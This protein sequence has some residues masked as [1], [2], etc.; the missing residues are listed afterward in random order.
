MQDVHQEDGPPLKKQRFDGEA[1]APLAGTAEISDQPAAPVDASTSQEATDVSAPASK[2]CDPDNPQSLAWHLK[3]FTGVASEN[4]AAEALAGIS[5]YVNPSVPA[6]ASA[7]I[8]HRF[9]DFLVWEI[10]RGGEVVRLKNIARPETPAMQPQ[11]EQGK[12][13][14][15]PAAAEVEAAQPEEPTLES[16]VDAVKLEEIEGLAAGGKSDSNVLTNPIESKDARKAFHNALRKKYEGKLVSEA[17]DGGVINVTWGSGK[18]RERRSIRP[19]KQDQQGLPPFI[20][21]T[22]Q[23][24]NR[25]TQDCISHLASRIGVTPK[26]FGTAGTKDKRGVTTQLV[27]VRRYK[28]TIE[29]LWDQVNGLHHGRSR[30]AFR[31]GS[32]K[33][34]GNLGRDGMMPK[35]RGERGLRIGDLSYTKDALDLGMLEGNKFG[36]VLRDVQAQSEEVINA[37]LQTL[38]DTGFINFYGMQRFGNSSVPTHAVGLALLQSDW[39]G[40]AR[41]VMAERDGD[42]DELRYARRCWNDKHDARKALQNMPKWAVAERCLL[43]FYQKEGDTNHNGALSRIPKNLRMMY[44]HAYQSYVWNSVASERVKVHGCEKPVVGDLVLAEEDKSEDKTEEASGKLRINGKITQQSLQAA[45]KVPKVKVL[46]EADIPNYTMHDVVLPL[47][48]YSVSYPG[49]DLGKMYREMM[50]ADGLDADSMF[51]PQREF[52]LGG[53]Y[54]KILTKPNNTTWEVLHYSDS[55]YP[56]MQA[57]EDT[58]LGMT[59]PPPEENA[60]KTAIKVSFDLDTS[61]Y[62]TMALREIL[63]SETSNVHQKALTDAMMARDADKDAAKE[64]SAATATE[65][66]KAAGEV[67]TVKATEI[68]P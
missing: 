51:R 43:E 22:L 48:G 20:Q 54:R 66:E 38:H 50:K 60:D 45:S 40:A 4:N 63:K 12:Q 57:D 17:Q 44:V 32:Y 1:S 10:A 58:L 37:A 23:K 49:G 29:E 33:K 39:E 68:A 24:T 41:L 59:L 47:P 53:A 36:I 62:A 34:G 11:P 18:S 16:L 13:E 35:E 61:S 42:N 6:F 9:T 28:R 14:D 21:F 31:G 19:S 67:E 64:A 52:S 55:N 65:P 5:G 3:Q 46:E 26:D 27:T 15:K 7:I 2:L 8:K 56:L 30:D 25:E